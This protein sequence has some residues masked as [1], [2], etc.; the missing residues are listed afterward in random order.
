MLSNFHR[1]IMTKRRT[2]ALIPLF[3]VILLLSSCE[4]TG[5]GRGRFSFIVTSDH[6]YH[7]TERF[8]SQ[9]YTLGGYEAI[10]AVGQGDFMVIVGDMD[11]TQATDALIAGVFGEDYP[12]YPVVGNH[13]IEDLA[14]LEYIQAMNKPEHPLPRVVNRGPAGCEATNYSFDWN[15]VHFVVIDVFYEESGVHLKYT[16]I[17]D[18]VLEWLEEDLKQHQ[19]YRIFIFGHKSVYPILDMESGTQRHVNEVLD[20]FPDNSLQFQ[21]ILQRYHVTAYFSGHTHAASWANI[22]GIWHL[23]SGH[24]YGQEGDY[25]PEKLFS[26]MSAFVEDAVERGV[27]ES[28]A[29]RMFFEADPKQ[30][31]KIIFWLDPIPGKDYKV[32]T[33]E[34]T[35]TALR[36]F[37]EDCR[38]DSLK[39]TEYSE[40][41]WKNVDWRKSTFMKIQIRGDSAVL[42]IYRDTGFL[43]NYVLRHTQV[44]Y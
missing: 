41:F 6:R 2:G 5:R 17:D 12:W 43:G 1:I 37:F 18:A 19:G 25:T 29:V 23:N 16:P 3:L 10:K 39:I 9:E 13:D 35:I 22:N 38:S 42:E 21:Q 4:S 11:P 15:G 7:A 40:R 44:L 32:L 28:T 27:T 24:I 34:Q 31:R 8:H 30:M 20:R 36:R 14:N 26:S 33:A